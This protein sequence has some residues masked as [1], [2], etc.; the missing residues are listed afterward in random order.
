MNKLEDQLTRFSALCRKTFVRSLCN[1]LS[2]R[3]LISMTSS[4][5]RKE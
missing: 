4:N 5:G 3:S 2:T 1:I